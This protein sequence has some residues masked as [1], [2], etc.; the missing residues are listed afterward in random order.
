M[1]WRRATQ[2]TAGESRFGAERVKGGQSQSQRESTAGGGAAAFH[3]SDSSVGL[4][5]TQVTTVNEPKKRAGADTVVQRDRDQGSEAADLTQD[6][7]PPLLDHELPLR[8][9]EVVEQPHRRQRAA[10]SRS[11]RRMDLV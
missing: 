5:R 9:R 8:G 3:S 4:S 2:V 11:S 1:I 6:L 7:H 10:V